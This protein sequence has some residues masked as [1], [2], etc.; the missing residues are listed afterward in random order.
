MCAVVPGGPS[1]GNKPSDCAFLT[2][3]RKRDFRKAT[4]RSSR[5]VAL[6]ALRALALLL[7]SLP[8]VCSP[9]PVRS[10]PAL[11]R[12]APRPPIWPGR[13]GRSAVPPGCSNNRTRPPLCPC[14]FAAQHARAARSCAVQC[15]PIRSAPRSAILAALVLFPPCRAPPHRPPHLSSAACRNDRKFARRGNKPQWV[16]PAWPTQRNSFNRRLVLRLD[17]CGLSEMLVARAVRSNPSDQLRESLHEHASHIHPTSAFVVALAGSLQTLVPE[18]VH[19]A[20]RC[21]GAV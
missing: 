8:A 1:N 15:R 10:R 17:L 20:Q 4:V 12:P 14:N 9:R 7:P 11:P 5:V 16:A 19:R 6:V 13:L 3:R 21:S 18:S 2:Q